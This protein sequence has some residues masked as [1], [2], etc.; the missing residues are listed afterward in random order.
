MY[1]RTISVSTAVYTV[2][3]IHTIAD[4]QASTAARSMMPHERFRI[5]DN[6]A[7]RSSET[8]EVEVVVVVVIIIVVIL[9]VVVW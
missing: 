6:V 7:S 3:C 1:M 9:I 5:T 2:I 8:N 4:R